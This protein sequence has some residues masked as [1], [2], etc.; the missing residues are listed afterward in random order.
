MLERTAFRYSAT[1]SRSADC[2]IQSENER[3]LRV[4]SR[5]GGQLLHGS[6]RTVVAEIVRLHREYGCRGLAFS[7][8]VWS[9][10]EVHRSL[11]SIL[12]LLV[13]AGVWISPHERGWS[14]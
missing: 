9:P 11:L 7:F 14:W 6:P 1:P 12:P 8:P 4:G 5:G 2:A 3:L 10:D 13:E